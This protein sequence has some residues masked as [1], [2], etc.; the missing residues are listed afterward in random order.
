MERTEHLRHKLKEKGDT[1]QFVSECHRVR[2]VLF[3]SFHSDQIK[4]CHLQTFI[5][6]CCVCLGDDLLYLSFSSV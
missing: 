6:E 5:R 1:S 3:A 2:L 4:H